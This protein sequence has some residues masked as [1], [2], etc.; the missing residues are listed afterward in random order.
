MRKWQGYCTSLPVHFKDV[1]MNVDFLLGVTT[2]ITDDELD[3]AIRSVLQVGSIPL[4]VCEC[5]CFV[6]KLR[7]A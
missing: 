2:H 3:A 1:G 7:T 5:M 4:Y 6:I